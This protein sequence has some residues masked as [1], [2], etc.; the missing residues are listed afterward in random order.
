MPCTGWNGRWTRRAGAPPERLARSLLNLGSVE[1]RAGLLDASVA[2]SQQALDIYRELGAQYYQA[3]ALGN[4]AEAHLD[5]G[6]HT[7]ARRF[8]DEALTLLDGV[9]ERLAASDS[10]VVKGRALA[11]SGELPAAR[12]SWQ[13]AL[14]VLRR[15]GDPRADE[16][17]ELLATHDDQPG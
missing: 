14:R 10:L 12:D 11:A 16:V 5:S 15:A 7:Q 8:A 13:R 6:E 4:L 17:A 3:M 2:H 9:D 1:G